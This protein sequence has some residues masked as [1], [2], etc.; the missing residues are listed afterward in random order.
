MGQQSFKVKISPI[1]S[2]LHRQEQS[3][4]KAGQA[5]FPERGSTVLL[6][7]QMMGDKETP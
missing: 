3:K 6:N 1:L 4:R 7:V 2:A 5:R